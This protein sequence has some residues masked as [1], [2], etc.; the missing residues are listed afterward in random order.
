MRIVAGVV[1]LL[2][3]VTLVVSLAAL[4]E[5][6][7]ADR[8]VVT[9]EASASQA[10]ATEQAPPTTTTTVLTAAPGVVVTSGRFEEVGSRSGPL[11]V[12]VT[13]GAL[14]VSA[15]IE[16]VGFDAS[17]DEMEVPRSAGIVGW[18]EY[19]ALP[20]QSGSAVL[21][22]HVDWNGRRG[23]FFDLYRVEPGTLVSVA[24]DDG[25]VR[26]FEVFA[27]DQFDKVDLP[28]DRVFAKE[29]NPVLTLVT[30][31]G[32]F[33]AGAGSY[34]DNVVVFAR[35]VTSVVPAQAG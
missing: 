5:R 14:D 30:C 18:Y 17:R 29:G 27:A 2:S 8:P 6:G 7:V 3:L 11:P 32:Y 23:A 4:R 13:I 10:G 21:A 22:A 19:S 33:D 25:S 26:L 35:P 24:F 31:G 9:F 1:A 12:S 34:D 16:P 28:T 15:S 20:G